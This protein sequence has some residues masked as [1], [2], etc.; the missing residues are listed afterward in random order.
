[1]QIEL[2]ALDAAA[3]QSYS[4]CYRLESDN[5]VLVIA[6]GLLDSARAPLEANN[7]G[8][9]SVFNACYC[10]LYYHNI[11]TICRN[12]ILA[13]TLVLSSQKDWGGVH[14]TRGSPRKPA[15]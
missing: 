7:A 6:K 15:E 1:M 8:V 5:C 14:G 3:R 12:C 2:A 4:A 10:T 11:N 13:S 9:G